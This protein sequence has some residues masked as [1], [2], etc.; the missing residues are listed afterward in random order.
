M[1][2]DT[3]VYVQAVKSGKQLSD[4]SPRGEVVWTVINGATTQTEVAKKKKKRKSK[5]LLLT[6]RPELVS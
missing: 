6:G 3:Q 4:V 2:T 1:V 5:W